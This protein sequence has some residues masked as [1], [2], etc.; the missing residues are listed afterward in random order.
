MIHTIELICDITLDE[1]EDISNQLNFTQEEL[2]RLFDNLHFQTVHRS[3]HFNSHNPETGIKDFFV[4]RRDDNSMPSPSYYVII[5]I[6]PLVMINQELSVD[7]FYSSPH[8][9]QLLQD[10]FHD[11]MTYYLPTQGRLAHLNNWKCRRIDYSINFHFDNSRD[12]DLFLELTRKTSRYVRKKQKRISS[13]KINQQSTAEG[14]YSVKVIFYD[15][16]KQIEDVYTNIPTRQQQSLLQEA[17]NIVRFEVQCLKGRVLTL[18]R[19]YHFPNRSIL[20]FLN[21]SISH[22]ILIEEYSKSVGVA[23]FYSFY[24]ADKK[25]KKSNFSSPK[26]KHLVQLLQLI[27]QARHLSI[28]KEQF[29][30]GT[31]IRRTNIIVQ[32]SENTFRNYLRD[33]STLG[34]HPMLIPK[35]RR[36]THFTNPVHQLL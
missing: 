1:L 23:D 13:L 33:L 29:I 9:V 19:K 7:L 18:Q 5:R 26:K 28:A 31:R 35:E 17:N 15:K 14:N 34:I 25:I 12:K 2:F 3:H 8:N 22:D 21:E 4:F 16:Q 6:E 32:G 30:H 36:V 20:Y 10:A 11:I 27:A 24:W